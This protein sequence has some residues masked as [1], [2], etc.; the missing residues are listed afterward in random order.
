MYK[1]QMMLSERK[2][3]KHRKKKAKRIFT[4]ILRGMYYTVKIVIIFLAIC[5]CFYI[6]DRR[7][8][9]EIPEGKYIAAAVNAS[10]KKPDAV[11]VIDAGHGGKDQGTCAGKVVEKEINLAVAEELADVLDMN[12]I[13][14]ILTRNSDEFVELLDRAAI[15]NEAQADFFVSIHCNYCEESSSVKGLECYFREGSQSGEML[16]ESIIAAC[17]DSD[18]VDPRGTKTEDFSVLRNT[19]MPAVL[20]ELGYI[21][22]K[23]ECRKLADSG[24][25]KEISKKL[26]KGICDMVNLRIQYKTQ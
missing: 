18:L 3:I 11:I 2:R 25:Q 22:N 17:E 1:K 14:V 15:A 8:K 21:S 20:I 9:N 16:A 19:Q 7:I 24:Y 5:G 12:N 26:A 23:E 13:Q 6:R 10:G 4:S